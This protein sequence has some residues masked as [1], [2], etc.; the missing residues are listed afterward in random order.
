HSP[1]SLQIL[2]PLQDTSGLDSSTNPLQWLY[3]SVVLFLHGNGAQVLP[4][5]TFGAFVSGY[6]RN[7]D[8]ARGFGD[9]SVKAWPKA[10]QA[11]PF[12]AARFF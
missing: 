6:F 7:P 12:T 4:R 11:A 9:L 3:L 1:L 10:L 5:G 2:F 8:L